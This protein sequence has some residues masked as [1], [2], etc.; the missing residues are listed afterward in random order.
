MITARL[1]GGLGNQMFQ[2]AAA[3]NLANKIGTTTEFQI[4]SQ[5]YIKNIF[6]RLSNNKVDIS[7]IYNEPCF[8]FVML[9]E[10]DNLCLNGYFQSEKYFIDNVQKIKQIFAETEQISEYIDKKYSKYNLINCTSLH[11]RRGDYLKFPLIHP[12]CDVSYYNK[13]L[14]HIDEYEN[15]IIF[16]DDIKWCQENFNFKNMIFVQGEQDYIDLY[17]MSRCKNNII[18]NSTFSWW[19]AWLNNNKN[20]KIIAPKNWFGPVGPQDVYDLIPNEWIIL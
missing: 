8:H 2:I 3:I 11:V 14:Q 5:K 20:K 12:V 19:S 16:S 6:S 4:D 7:F 13:A 9:P 17:L 10:H 1:Q 15:L 18:A